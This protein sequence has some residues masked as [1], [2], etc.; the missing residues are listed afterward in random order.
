MEPEGFPEAP[1]KNLSSEAE[2]L[3]DR[4]VEGLN[5][6]S[7][8]KQHQRGRGAGDT[9]DGIKGTSAR[10][11]AA[12]HEAEGTIATVSSAGDSGDRS[13]GEGAESMVRVARDGSPAAGAAEMAGS[14]TFVEMGEGERLR[15][16][17][18]E[19]RNVQAVHDSVTQLKIDL[20]L[21]KLPHEPAER[22]A[23][24]ARK[25]DA[26]QNK[27]E[28]V[29]GE[30]R[31]LRENCKEA[32]RL[33]AAAEVAL[34]KMDVEYGQLLEASE[35]RRRDT[36]GRVQ[37]LEEKCREQGAKLEAEA[38]REAKR[39]AEAEEREAEL[40]IRM[41][42]LER[43]V[44]EQGEALQSQQAVVLEQR[45]RAELLEGELADARMSR[46]A[47]SASIGGASLSLRHMEDAA[48]DEAR[49]RQM[50]EMAERMNS[51]VKR[52]EEA[53][54]ELS[55][56]AGSLEKER[57][58]SDDLAGKLREEGKVRSFQA[59]RVA[60]LEADMK[61]L[62]SEGKR[63]VEEVDSER[64]RTALATMQLEKLRAARPRNTSPR[65]LPMPANAS[66]DVGGGRRSG[67]SGLSGGGGGGG[68]GEDV[69]RLK[70][71][72]ARLREE[73]VT[74]KGRLD[75]SKR[76]IEANKA[77]MELWSSMG[78]EVAGAGDWSLNV[79]SSSSARGV[80]R[81]GRATAVALSANEDETER[82]RSKVS[83]QMRLAR[84]DMRPPRL[85]S[86]S[87][88]SPSSGFRV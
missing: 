2:A 56:L 47:A 22:R 63:L 85:H 26:L 67:A 60:K 59:R 46:D 50:V 32:Y 28:A 35:A 48:R 21:G 74:L 38:E 54:A 87:L 20:E 40:Q 5:T 86:W 24:V 25:M 23:F 45:S 83:A 64:A 66:F 37:M 8:V 18:E 72:V 73:V 15:V 31:V 12:S 75:R 80:A 61:A 39:D 53:E 34:D 57:E 6:P 19:W 41:G 78:G 27:L 9:A 17:E 68:G 70:E 82:L 52:A 29:Q 79:S 36:E 77:S 42:A 16:L 7:P 71:E 88:S 44:E 33:K 49:G 84:N 55:R 13:R 11:E 58:R 4:S 81:G 30:A 14:A 10:A 1:L 69:G 3:L 76:Q 65:K 62:R 51:A 43:M